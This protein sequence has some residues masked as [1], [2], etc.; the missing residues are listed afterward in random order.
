MSPKKAM[1]KNKVQAASELLK[2]QKSVLIK[3]YIRDK[4]KSELFSKPNVISEE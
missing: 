3:N 4:I 2:E 1:T